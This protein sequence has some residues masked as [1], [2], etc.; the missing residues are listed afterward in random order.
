MWTIPN[1]NICSCTVRSYLG[2]SNGPFDSFDDEYIN[3]LKKMHNDLVKPV[4]FEYG[5]NFTEV[6]SDMLWSSLCA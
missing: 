6:T 4:T 5:Y 3:D 1:C 2:V